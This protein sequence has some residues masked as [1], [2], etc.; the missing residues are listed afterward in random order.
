MKI[1]SVIGARPQ[2]IKASAV[3]RALRK[4]HEEFLVHTGQHYDY[5]M[6]D[7]FFKGLELPTADVNL[8][9]GSGSHGAQTGAMLSGIET[10]LQREKPD[11][12]L[13]YGDTNSTVSGALAAAKLSVKVVHVEAGLR[14]FNRRMPEEIN[15]VVAD[16]L[17]TLLLCTSDEGVRNLSAEGITKGVHV[18]GDVMADV[19]KWAQKRLATEPSN[20]LDE[21]DLEQ[22]SYLLATVHRSENTDD[23]ERLAQ[24]L[25]A[26]NSIDEVLVFPVHP[27]TR[28]LIRE[29]SYTLKPHIKLINPV[30]YLEMVT[31]TSNARMILTDSGGLQKEAYWL[32]VPCLTMRNE[33]EWV[34]TVDAGWNVLVG[35]DS[36]KIFGSVRSFAPPQKHPVLYGD[37]H[38]SERCVELLRSPV[39][40]QETVLSASN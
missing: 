28:K 17:S 25:D 6:S 24:I 21:L 9:V 13:I 11:Y 14:S 18:V 15:R 16:H 38:A 19:L 7:I 30:G 32:N 31:L 36:A 22:N 2:M 34:E 8:N 23:P 3:S 39:S 37:G 29:G 26:F 10:V 1:V 35:C 27:R 5:E 12:L 4:E 33:T 40:H 20:I